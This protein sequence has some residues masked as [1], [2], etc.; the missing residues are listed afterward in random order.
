ML[1][2]LAVLGMKS[3]RLWLAHLAV[4]R[5]GM[6][7]RCR[8]WLARLAALAATQSKGLA[9]RRLAVAVPAGS[10]GSP[11]TRSPATTLASKAA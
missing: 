2:L 6:K 4:C 8:L 10:A 11:T 9:A 7:R 5:L 3:R 1:A